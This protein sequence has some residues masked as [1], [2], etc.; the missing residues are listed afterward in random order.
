MSEF[1]Q[2]AAGWAGQTAF[3]GAILLLLGWLGIKLARCPARRHVLA[4]WVLRA[5]AIVPV[6]CLIPTW[7]KVPVPG[8]LVAE[9]HW[10]VPRAQ[11]SPFAVAEVRNPVIPA[12]V[13]PGPDSTATAMM[14]ERSPRSNDVPAVPWG[15]AV[16]ARPDVPPDVVWNLPRE[17][18]AELPDRKVK[19]TDPPLKRAGSP[20]TADANPPTPVPPSRTLASWIA[21]VTVTIYWGVSLVLFGQVVLGHLTLLGYCRAG[22]RAPARVQ[23]V[24][25]ELAAGFRRVPRLVVS[26]R[27]SSPACFGLFRPTV[28]L[29]TPFAVAATAAELRWVF[30]H[31]FDHLR[32]G[33]HRTA[34]WLGTVRAMYFFVPWFWPLRQD[35]ALTQEYLA[36]AAAASAGGSPVD[37]AAFLVSLSGGPMERRPARP[38]FPASG[39]RPGRSDLFRRVTM[40]VERTEPRPERTPRSWAVFAAVGSLTAAVLLSGLGLAAPDEKPPVKTPDPAQKDPV[41]EEKP[42]DPV[43][44]DAPREG[45]KPKDP[46]KGDKPPVK[47]D[48]PRDGYKPRDPNA[49][50]DGDKPREVVI[51]EAADELKRKIIAAASTGNLEELRKLTEKLAMMMAQQRGDPF[52]GRR[53]DSDEVAKLKQA[54]AER[55]KVFEDQIEKLKGIPEA[56]VALRRAMDEYRR[57]IELSL[58]VEGAKLDD[59]QAGVQ[60]FLRTELLSKRGGASARFG[61]MVAPVPEALVEQLDLPKNR[62]L[63]VTG[64]APGSVAEKAGLKKNDILLAFAGQDISAEAGKFVEQVEKV[65]GGQKFDVIVLRKGKKET[66]NGVELAEVKRIEIQ[67][68]EAARV[69]RI[70]FEQMQV[71]VSND[72]FH[73]DATKGDVKYAIDGKRNGGKLEATSI[74]IVSGKAKDNYKAFWDVPDAHQPAVTQLL[75]SIR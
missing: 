6:L 50:R 17:P 29:P 56:Q 63:L 12:D 19:P 30:A 3:T 1:W 36:D 39:A 65:K 14:P 23:A 38:P 71:Q 59:H 41:K 67:L 58:K 35:L 10:P 62:G 31:E 74:V 11:E 5:A 53:G 51:V 45:D 42:K 9:T 22:G 21:P 72:T 69:P 70:E 4:G 46:T 68:R 18:V 8:W 40:L 55:L 20:A 26:D 34:W 73:I 57:S 15:P 7:V 66:I 32:R 48:A 64:V 49:R 54:M 60:D 28:L 16:P 24:F 43:K 33:D 25:D 61:V 2:S 27:V 52:G 47:G 75:G 44:G 13:L 37:Y